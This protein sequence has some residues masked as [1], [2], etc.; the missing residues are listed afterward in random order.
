MKLLISA[1]LLG[2]RCRYDG[3][4]K[5]LPAETLRKLREQHELIP[6]CPEQAGGLPTPRAP[7]ERR[8]VKV[9]STEGRDVTREYEAGAGSA[10]ELAKKA[11]VDAAL[12]KA[13]SPSCGKGEIYD[14]TF[15]R[16]L[17]PG[18]GV[19]AE[20]LERSGFPVYTEEEIEALI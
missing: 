17:I 15:S 4:S 2:E 7:S 3:K 6:V 18:S 11:N 9:V 10:L 5:P 19:T 12:L 13:R 1:C 8:G 20:L 16:T 14:G